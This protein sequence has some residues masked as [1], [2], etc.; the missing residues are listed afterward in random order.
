MCGVEGRGPLGWGGGF[1]VGHAIADQGR[2]F[3][4]D[5]GR[6]MHHGILLP[7]MFV[8]VEAQSVVGKGESP[9]VAGD[10]P[11]AV[12]G[13]TRLFPESVVGRSA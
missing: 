5:V 7:W 3:L 9:R 1:F 13:V 4:L 11:V 2:F 6:W 8:G 10:P 12:G